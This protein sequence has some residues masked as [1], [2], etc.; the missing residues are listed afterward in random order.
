M[1]DLDRAAIE[2][3]PAVAASEA[4]A[5]DFAEAEDAPVAILRG[6]AVE[7]DRAGPAGNAGAVIVSCGNLLHDYVPGIPGGKRIHPTICPVAYAAKTED[8]VG[9]VA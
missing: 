9:E 1:V 2:S 3:V 4:T 7:D 5:D 6:D 8:K